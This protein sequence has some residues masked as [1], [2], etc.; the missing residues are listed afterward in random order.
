MDKISYA[1]IGIIAFLISCNAPK[2]SSEVLFG[3][4]QDRLKWISEI[5]QELIDKKLTGSN[6]ILIYKDNRVIYNQI[7]NS[8]HPEDKDITSE[9]L[10]PIWSMSKPITTVAVMILFEEGKLL[11]DDPI[12][13]YL[14]ELDSMN[15]LD[16]NGNIYRCEEN[17]TIRHLLT[18]KSGISY[19][20]QEIDGKFYLINDREYKDLEDFVKKTGEYPLLF[21][22]GTQYLYG[23]NTAVLGRLV[24]VIS[25]QEY[26]SF[27]KERLFDPLNMSN[28]DFDL[29]EDERNYFQPLF[30]ISDT[31]Q[32]PY[33]TENDELSYQPGSKVQLGG[34]GLISTTDD[35]S[36]FCE[37]LL[38]NGIYKGKRILSPTSVSWMHQPENDCPF[39]G[40]KSGF[41]FFHLTD[42]LADGSLSPQGIFGWGG[43]HNTWFWIDQENELF[44]L[45]MTRGSGSITDRSSVFQQVRLATYQAIY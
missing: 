25:G 45:I 21:E 11:L 36:H 38:H 35:Y 19:H 37:M 23:L 43:Y 28:T 13:K 14:P 41:T 16:E 32:N 24:E 6:H 31:A 5:Q 17:I 10:F 34:E 12:G 18:H 26:Y 2:D 9:T 1:I 29:A 7:C 15:Y 3:Y 44:G 27:L 4:D 33:T 40:F 20:P 42:P 8:G 22:P 30:L 39:N